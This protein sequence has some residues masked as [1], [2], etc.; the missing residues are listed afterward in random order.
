MI[1]SSTERVPS[2]TSS[3]I[4]AVIHERAIESIEKYR[5]ASSDEI[6]A[7]IEELNTEFDIERMLEANAATIAL[8]GIILGATVNK[9]W[10]ILSGLVTGFLLQHALQGWCP[11]LPVLRKLG[12]RTPQEIDEELYALKYLRGDFGERS[13]QAD[14]VSML[15][16]MSHH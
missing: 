3:Q 16:M 1:P 6:T 14:S 12:F 8:S 10:L 13:Q 11:P 2:H 4:N 7:R 5:N 9:K 15:Q